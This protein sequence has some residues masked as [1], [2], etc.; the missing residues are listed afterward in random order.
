MLYLLC[1]NLH[2]SYVS[3]IDELNNFLAVIGKNYQH[4]FKNKIKRLTKKW[5]DKSIKY[6]SQK[7]PLKIHSCGHND[8]IDY[9]CFIA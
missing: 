8:K 7:I 1:F 4:N 9:N 6:F 5:I 3:E 2:S